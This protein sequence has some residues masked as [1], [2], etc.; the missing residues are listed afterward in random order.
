MFLEILLKSVR[1]RNPA[2]PRSSSSSFKP[3][4]LL[5]ILCLRTYE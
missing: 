1:F 5:F 4:T 2:L 3:L